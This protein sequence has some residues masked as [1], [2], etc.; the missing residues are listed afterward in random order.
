MHCCNIYYAHEN[1]ACTRLSSSLHGHGDE[2]WAAEVTSNSYSRGVEK[3]EVAT[4]GWTQPRTRHVMNV[5]LM[6]GSLTT[7]LFTPRGYYDAYVGPFM[8]H[9]PPPPPPPHTH[10]HT[11]T[12][13]MH[14][15]TSNAT[16]HRNVICGMRPA[17]TISCQSWLCRRAKNWLHRPDNKAF[18]QRPA[19][20]LFWSISP[21]APPSSKSSQ[22]MITYRVA[23]WRRVVLSKSGYHLHD[24]LVPNA[25]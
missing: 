15:H 7:P 16:S 13:G 11:H 5:A 10:T 2:R 8:Y 4:V 17:G 21:Q 9:P 14:T 23:I 20:L 6:V 19:K 3:S 12:T 1:G 24:A 18:L 25:V 22:P